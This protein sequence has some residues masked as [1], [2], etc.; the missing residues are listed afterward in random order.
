MDSFLA[1]RTGTTGNMVVVAA[2][3]QTHRSEVAHRIARHKGLEQKDACHNVDNNLHSTCNTQWGWSHQ[4][5]DSSR[6]S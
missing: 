5:V 6:A 3:Q 4:A 2:S 1:D